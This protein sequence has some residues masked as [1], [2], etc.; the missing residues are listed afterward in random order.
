MPT[1]SESTTNPSPEVFK[2]IFLKVA[3]VPA[4]SWMDG[5][6][7]IAKWRFPCYQHQ[8]FCI[9]SQVVQA[10]AYR[11]QV[12]KATTNTSCCLALQ[13]GNSCLPDSDKY[14]FLLSCHAGTCL[15]YDI[16][17]INIRPTGSLKSTLVPS[18]HFCPKVNA[19]EGV[20]EKD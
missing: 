2:I 9:F 5:R 15:Y 20:S 11:W 12:D 19:L 17:S 10:V 14:H 13:F 8:N 6:F 18:V 3:Y 1:L 4:Q 7:P 16:L